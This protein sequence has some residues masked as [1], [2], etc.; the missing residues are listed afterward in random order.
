MKMHLFAL[1]L[2]GFT[3]W[4]QWATGQTT[5]IVYSPSSEDFVNPERG[6][7]RYSATYSGNYAYLNV[8]EM[9]S[10]RSLQQPQGAN[11]SVY[12]SLVFRYFFLE[13]F[14]D[15]PIAAW[16][17]AAMTQDFAAAREA[18]VK[19]IVRFAY[20]DDPAAGGCQFC[21]PY[22]DAPKAIVLQHIAQ[23]KP[24]LQANADVIATV[25]MGFIGIWG[26]GYY[27]DYFG[28]ASQPPYGLTAQNWNDRKAVVDAL[29][30]ALPESR[31]VQVRYPQ[32]KQKS[33]YG[34]A[35]PTTSLPLSPIEAWQNTAKARIGFHNDCFLASADDFGTYANYDQG[36][37]GSDTTRLKPYFS[38]DAQFVPVGGETC[39]DWEPYSNCLGQPGG[40]AESEMARLHYSYL[41]AGYNNAV[42]ND[43]T[44][45][46]CMSTI[47]QRLGYRLELQQGEYSLAAQPGQSVFVKI[48][49]KNTGFAAPF[50]PRA[51]RLLL[52]NPGNSTIYFVELPEEPRSWLAGDSV[53]TLQYDLCLPQDIPLGN[54]E[55]LLHLADPYPALFDR[56]EYALRL[57]NAGN[58]WDPATGYNN[59]LHQISVN[60]LAGNPPCMGQ[61][62][63][64]NGIVNTGQKFPEEN[65]LWKVFPN[66]AADAVY[67]LN[68]GQNIGVVRYSLFNAVGQL[69][70]NGALDYSME[71][72][73]QPIYLTNQSNGVYFLKLNW[74]GGQ[75][76]F[77]VLIRS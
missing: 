60:Q 71:N 33:V 10:W 64:S 53:Y 13:T 52:R 5:T 16:Y 11:Y 8:S 45:A 7:Y 4:T 9:K 51:M 24:L 44:T 21:P 55:L 15:S 68:A 47:K 56:P 63:F 31:C 70:Q 65:N 41:N 20:T 23:L 66:P 40:I 73:A 27:T 3:A 46:G 14:K 42:N 28:D 57:A 18:G 67:I 59:L 75:S 19:L 39:F 48:E 30:D 62:T 1:L 77:R 26:E 34:A 36:S 29:L 58:L 54:Y 49:L 74:S 25:Q 72:T 17:L 37:A 32:M 35:A 12:S 50:N 38:Q 6:F 22:G 69:C 2:I 76:L 43:W 61:L